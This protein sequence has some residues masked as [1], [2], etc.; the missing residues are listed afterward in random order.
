MLP[1]CRDCGASTV[2]PNLSRVHGTELSKY[3]LNELMVEEDEDNSLVGEQFQ[4]VRG[5]RGYT[6]RLWLGEADENSG[7]LV[8]RNSWDKSLG[9]LPQEHSPQVVSDSRPALLSR[10]TRG[11]E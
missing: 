1:E 11:E 10:W 2:S 9:P 6:L 3:L 4:R 8:P 7:S 5:S